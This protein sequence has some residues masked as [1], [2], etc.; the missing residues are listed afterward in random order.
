MR[1]GFELAAYVSVIEQEPN[2]HNVYRMLI[3]DL[4]RRFHLASPA[5]RR[6]VLAK[7]PALTGARWD[8]LLAAVVEHITRLHGEP[9]PRWVDEPERFLDTPWG[10]LTCGRSALTRCCTRPERSSGTV[11]YRTRW[12]SMQGA[13]R[14]MSG[15]RRADPQFTREDIVRALE[16]LSERLAEREIRAH[17]Y[18]VGGAAMMLAH[19][20]S[21]GTVDVDA[22]MIDPREVVMEAASEVA[23]EQRLDTDWLNDEVRWMPAHPGPLDT[24]AHVLFESPNLVVTGASARHVLGMKVRAGRARDVEDIELLI[25]QLGVTTIEEVRD[26]HSAVF[27]HEGMSP[28]SEQRVTDVLS[29]HKERAERKSWALPTWEDCGPD[30]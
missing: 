20:R 29:K 30:R 23:R 11:R 24:A 1:R 8:A 4:P 25:Q 10:S 2:R 13:A 17:I 27:P 9:V 6:A 15:S 3:H 22:L 7:Q 19:R 16:A 18:V 5:E 14:S 28:R 21:K 26:I 12:I